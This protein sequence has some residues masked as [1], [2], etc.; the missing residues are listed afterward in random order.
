MRPVLVE[1]ALPDAAERAGADAR[2]RELLGGPDPGPVGERLVLLHFRGRRTGR[3]LT[4]PAGIH[5]LGGTLVVA[6]GS[7]W[8][9]NFAVPGAD[10]ELTWRGSRV[11]AHFTL[12]RDSARTARGYLELYE[13]YGEEAPRR[14]GL[15]VTGTAAP[16]LDAFTRAVTDCGLSLV[17]IVPG[18]AAPA[19]RGDADA[20]DDTVN[21]RTP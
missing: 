14:L 5:R 18:P 17:E 6:T 13:R 21:E 7:S 16:D 4:L 11:P 10:G 3:A 12:V 19:D 15:R 1:R 2:V 8:R 20:S 9:H